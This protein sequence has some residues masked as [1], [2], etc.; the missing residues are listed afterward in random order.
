M[1]FGKTDFLYVAESQ[2]L[3]DD[4]DFCPFLSFKRQKGQ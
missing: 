2:K 1:V 3:D 4:V